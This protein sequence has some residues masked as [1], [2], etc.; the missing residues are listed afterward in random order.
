MTRY[1]ADQYSRRAVLELSA[2][3]STVTLGLLAGCTDGTGEGEDV[4]E[5]GR[6]ERAEPAEDL[7]AVAE[8]LDDPELEAD[9]EWEDVD[10][11]EL[12][13]DTDDGWTGRRPAVVDGLENPDLA[14][15]EDREYEFRW[16]NVDGDVHNLAFWDADGSRLSSSPFV[17]EEGDEQTVTVEAT[18]KMAAYLC[19][20]HGS[21]MAGALEIRSE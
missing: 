19:E 16:T 1:A 14:L 21:D 15:Y 13:A 11:I 4:D 8:D 9:G 5:E 12:E 6:E 3:G 10:L 7:E 18:E 17:D 20:T 2:T